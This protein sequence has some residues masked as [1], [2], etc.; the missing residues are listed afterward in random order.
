[1]YIILAYLTP[2]SKKISNNRAHLVGGNQVVNSMCTFM[3][4]IDGGYGLEITIEMLDLRYTEAFWV[5]T[6]CACVTLA[7]S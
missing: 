6:P 1:M 3:K 5:F 4:F 2:I 7:F